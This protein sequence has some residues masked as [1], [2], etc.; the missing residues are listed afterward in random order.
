VTEQEDLSDHP[1][2]SGMKID[3]IF[4]P[5]IR[6]LDFV[7]DGLGIFGNRAGDVVLLE[8]VTNFFLRHV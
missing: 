3:C 6:K 1:T 7:V 2:G 5:K 8:D 4:P